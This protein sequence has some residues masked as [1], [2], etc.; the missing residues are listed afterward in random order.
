M[1]IS[2]Y[3]HFC[4][5]AIA[6]AII[7]AASAVPAHSETLRWITYKPQGANDPQAITTQW[8]ADEVKKLTGGKTDIQI[9]WGGTVAKI[10]EIPN[11]LTSGVGQI[12][13]IVTPYFPDKFVI[14]NAASFFIPQPHSTIALGGLM[15]R[16]NTQYP[17]LDKEM[18][19]YN[20][21]VVGYRPLEEYGMICTKPIRNAKEFAG[22]RV[23]S[24]GF[25]LPALIKALGATPVSMSTPEAYEALQRGILD[26]SPVGPTLAHGWKYDDVAKYYINI[27]LGALWGHLIA[28]NLD[29]YKKLDEQSRAAIDTVGTAYLVKYS[30][31]VDL[32]TQ[33]V[34]KLWKDKL[35]VKII[36]FAH[37]DLVKASQS[38]AVKEVRKKWI[39]KAGATGLPAQ[40][41]ADEL[42]LN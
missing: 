19:K 36:P 5:S 16:W 39:E 17:Q 8:F 32:Q 35:G 33:N 18:A 30:T 41:I 11:A 10:N 31:Q 25:A 34:K 28:M 15:E 3:K 20:L 38:D 37:E 22:V 40:D 21:K 4:G 6:V 23:R 1:R 42:E 26:C 7:G 24:F 29:A 12:G 13:D 14:N 2:L 9:S 27:R